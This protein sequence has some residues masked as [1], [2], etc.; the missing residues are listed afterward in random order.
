MKKRLLWMVVILLLVF[1]AFPTQMLAQTALLRIESDAWIL[2]KFPVRQVAEKFQK[3]HPEIKVTVAPKEYKEFVKSYLL[4]WQGGETTTD[5][6]IGGMPLQL[7]PL[8]GAD[9]LVDLG[10][11][12][13]GNMAREKFVQAYL[14]AGRFTREGK[15]YYPVMPFMGELMILNVNK[16]LYA[17]AGLVDA[18]G[19]PLEAKD[20]DEFED[21]LRKLKAVSPGFAL[22]VDWGWNFIFYSYAGGIQAIKSNIYSPTAPRILDFESD[23]PLKWLTLNQKWI[24]EGLA[25]SGTITDVN[26]GRNNFKAGIIP[27]IYTAHSRFIEAGET[28]GEENTSM[29]PIPGAMKNGS[30]IYTHAVYI[31]K[32]SPAIDLAKQ[33]IREQI[34]SRWFQQ[35]GYN[36]YGKLP[37]ISD[38]YGEGITWYQEETSRILEIA[39]SSVAMPKYKGNE[40]LLDILLEQIHPMLLGKQSPAKTLENIRESIALRKVDLTRLD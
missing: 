2:R 38:Y 9:L 30:I 23:A 24:K 22:S 7:A 1:L 33:F 6:G 20:W 17:K 18:Q 35:W 12:F 15:P 14:E 4:M 29:V 8:V 32:V 37:V 36:H 34:F 3:D 27:A 40:E 25:G 13:T 31:P 28:L 26:Y 11:M 16:Q 21:Q 39:K 5:L 19:N 10:D